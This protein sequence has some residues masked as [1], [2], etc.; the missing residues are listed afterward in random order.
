M[1]SKENRSSN[2]KMGYHFEI[3]KILQQSNY[4]LVIW[5]N[6]ASFCT[7]TSLLW[8]GCFAMPAAA[9]GKKVHILPSILTKNFDFDLGKIDAACAY[10]TCVMVGR[11]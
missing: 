11:N 1:N 7:T 6:E 8:I 5:K 10:T 3:Y 2:L 9:S 4:H